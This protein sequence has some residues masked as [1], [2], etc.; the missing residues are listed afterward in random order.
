M[1]ST[2]RIFLLSLNY[3]E[4]KWWR[5]QLSL[6]RD[7][8]IIF[9][10]QTACSAVYKS[11]V[12]MRACALCVVCVYVYVCVCVFMCMCVCGFTNATRSTSLVGYR[13]QYSTVDSSIPSNLWGIYSVSHKKGNPDLISN[14]W[15]MKRRIPKLI[16]E[17]DSTTIP[18]SYDTLIT[19]IG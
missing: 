3:W 17:N 7:T 2:V 16:T 4:T 15:K 14:L 11:R 6:L 1:C 13:E 12:K 19:H 18:L 8:L 9:P 10:Q 5:V